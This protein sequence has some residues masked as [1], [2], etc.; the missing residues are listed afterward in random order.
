MEGIK[1][2]VSYAILVTCTNPSLLEK[3]N[4]VIFP[5][6]NNNTDLIHIGVPPYLKFNKKSYNKQKAFFLSNPN[7][8]IYEFTTEEKRIK[9]FLTIKNAKKEAKYIEEFIKTLKKDYNF[10]VNFNVDIVE[11]G[12]S[13][14]KI[15]ETI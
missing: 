8:C 14:K 10:K 1:K 6:H 12:F 15:N 11:I 2:E 3:E 4:G 9:R 13:I 7:W 5:E